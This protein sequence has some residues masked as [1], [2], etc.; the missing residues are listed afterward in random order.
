MFR[1]P[2]S[3][4]LDENDVLRNLPIRRASDFAAGRTR[5]RQHALELETVHHV[6]RTPVAQLLGLL[7]ELQVET[8]GDH[9]G[10]DLA[11]DDLGLHVEVDR[12]R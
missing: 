1:V 12:V 7:A 2:R 3:D 9:D 4:T 10:P 8:G 6:E 5:G 11:L